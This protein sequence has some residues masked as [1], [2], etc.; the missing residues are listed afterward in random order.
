MIS[1]LAGIVLITG[2]FFLSTIEKLFTSENWS[3]PISVSCK[4]VIFTW[5]TLAYSISL[6]IVLIQFLI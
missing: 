3:I 2:L 5:V 1:I 4:K 6:I